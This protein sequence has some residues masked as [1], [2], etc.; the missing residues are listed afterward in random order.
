M[1]Q[2]YSGLG[3]SAKLFGRRRNIHGVRGWGRWD[4][5]G[6]QWTAAPKEVG[7][8]H[9]SRLLYRW[10]ADRTAKRFIVERYLSAT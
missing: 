5:R 2:D 6:E 4:P 10:D 8:L 9:R 7:A 1:I 3:S